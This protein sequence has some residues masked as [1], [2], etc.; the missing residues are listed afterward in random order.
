MDHLTGESG[1]SI[2]ILRSN[3]ANTVPATTTAPAVD[4]GR[5]RNSP[6]PI[7]DAR[8]QLLPSNDVCRHLEEIAV[9]VS[10]RQTPKSPEWPS[11]N[12][13]SGSLEISVSLE[14]LSYRATS[15]LPAAPTD[16]VPS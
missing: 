9:E 4:F 14:D 12:H 5:P 13:I 10:F 15:S 2:R 8:P 16:L 11:I 3:L 7:L 6:L 1:L